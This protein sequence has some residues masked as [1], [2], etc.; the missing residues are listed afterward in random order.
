MMEIEWVSKMERKWRGRKTNLWKQRQIIGR[1]EKIKRLRCTDS[2]LQKVKV[3]KGQDLD[4]GRGCYGGVVCP[5]FLY[6]LNLSDSTFSHLTFFA[7]NL[8]NR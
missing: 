8:L 2:P 5:L 4:P 6:E 7:S 1:Y 3:N